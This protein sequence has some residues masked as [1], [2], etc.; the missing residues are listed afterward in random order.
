[1]FSFSKNYFLFYFS[2]IV[3]I[4]FLS[5]KWI[6][7]R[8]KTKKNLPPSPPKL[9]IIG[10][11]H[12]LGLSP[13]RSLRALSRKHGPL[14]LMH[15]GSVPVLVA[16][17][18]EAA[19]E[20][21]K[22]HDLKFCN[23]PKL[24]IVDIVVYGSNDITFSPYGEYW[25]Q[26]KSIA[27]VHLLNTTR[28]Q[29]FRK[30]REEEVGLMIDMIEKS[31]GSVVDLSELL[32]RLVNNIVCKA[33]L[34]RTYPGSKFADLL[35][36]FVW[37]LGAVSLGSYIPWLSW[38]KEEGMDVDA[39]S[40]EDQDLVDILLDVKGDNTTGFTFHRNTVKALILDVFAAGTD[41][42]FTSLVWSISELLRHPRVM[43]KL[44]QEVT[45]IAQGR[46][47]ILEKD[48]ENMQYLKA[49]IKE[50]LRMYPPIPL[51]IPHES[52][53][54]VKLLGYDIPAGTQTLVNAWAIGR[55]S[56]AW[57]EPEEFKPERF[58]NSSTNYK[59][60]HFELLPF[61]GGRR[62][63]PGIPFATVIFELA[64]AN[65]IYKFDLALP[66]GVK[67]TDLD[68]REKFG[69]TLHKEAHLLIMATPSF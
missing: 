7:T 31:S 4:I 12:Q 60:L 66:N 29:S 23:R 39:Q 50:T 58:L 24:R 55:D 15:F 51:L 6:S 69:I 1:M 3:L 8:L 25:R 27:V 45:K 26:V 34:G 30:T 48:L 19:K 2:F 63:C 17:S 67:N 49:V 20:I 28:V 11:L 18:P 54:D 52:T 59:G 47:M 37:V 62:G 21:M 10:N 57:E 36:R 41:T 32:F 44:K 9:P 43:E 61:G 13:Y 65:V 5:V 38:I 35:E 68:M 14:M 16:S 40:G 53:E 64:L 33:A 22:T 46:S 42:T 56:T